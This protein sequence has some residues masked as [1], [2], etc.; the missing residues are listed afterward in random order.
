MIDDG[1]VRIRDAQDT[2]ISIVEILRHITWTSLSLAQLGATTAQPGESPPPSIVA[3]G[4]FDG[5][6]T[7]M[8]RT[9]PEGRLQVSMFDVPLSTLWR[10][11]RWGRDVDPFWVHGAEVTAPAAG[12]ALVSKSVSAGRT[13]YIYGFFISSGEPNDF[14]INWTSGDTAYSI[15]IVFP[16]KG[17]L[18]YIDFTPLNE[19]LPADPGTTISITNVNAG[20]TGVVYQARLLYV[21]L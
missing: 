16:G 6:L 3:V 7:R 11:V 17:S 18:Q 8:L 21:E 10:L 2:S 4:G 14:R 5:S 1:F 13:G 12:T 9:D 15:R 20:S 19:G